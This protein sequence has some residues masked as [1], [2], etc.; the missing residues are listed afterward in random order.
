[1]E[2]NVSHDKL[3]EIEQRLES[4]DEDGDGRDLRV[5]DDFY[6]DGMN[7]YSGHTDAFSVPSENH[8]AED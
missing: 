7:E 4:E 6:P 2:D 8:D 5:I 1:M 3:E